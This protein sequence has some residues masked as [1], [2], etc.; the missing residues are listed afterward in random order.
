MQLE[1]QWTLSEKLAWSRSAI[2]NSGDAT[3]RSGALIESTF[4]NDGDNGNFEIVVGQETNFVHWYRN[5][6]PNNDKWQQ[7]A[8][9][10]TNAVWRSS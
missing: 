10:S 4:G 1:H 3:L 9:I 6:A 2:I 8:T 5:N 7:K